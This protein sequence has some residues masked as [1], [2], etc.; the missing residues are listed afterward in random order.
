MLIKGDYNTKPYIAKLTELFE[1]GEFGPEMEA[2]CYWARVQSMQEGRPLV[3][4]LAGTTEHHVV[5]YTHSAA[6][7]RENEIGSRIEPFRYF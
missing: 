3:S 1:D 5:E 6:Q 7:A 4:L 2:F